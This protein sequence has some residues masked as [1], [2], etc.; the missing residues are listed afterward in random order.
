MKL[1]K[2]FCISLLICLITNGCKGYKVGSLMHPQI[3]TIAFKSFGNDT[4]EPRLSIFMMEKLREA[5]M[6]DGS[7]KIVSPEKADCILEGRIQSYRLQSIG[8]VRQNNK[9]GIKNNNDNTFRTVIFRATVNFKFKLIAKSGKRI[10][11][12]SVS[13]YADFTELVDFDIEKRQ[14]LRNAAYATSKKVVIEI[15]EGW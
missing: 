3:K 2:L 13:S 4:D 6:K 10:K 7:L 14:G 5:F 11:E 9:N 8:S 1:L 12:A 15:V